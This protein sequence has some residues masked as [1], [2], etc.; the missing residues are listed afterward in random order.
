MNVS[1]PV[2]AFWPPHSWQ[3]VAAPARHVA[4]ASL[5]PWRMRPSLITARPGAAETKTHP[6]GLCRWTGRGLG[7]NDGTGLGRAPGGLLSFPGRGF[8]SPLA[9]ACSDSPRLTTPP[10]SSPWGPQLGPTPPHEPFHLVSN[11][12][13]T[14]AKTQRQQG[15]KWEKSKQTFVANLVIIHQPQLLEAAL[16]N[17]VALPSHPMPLHRPNHQQMTSLPW[18]HVSALRRSR[19]HLS[20]TLTKIILL[21][22]LFCAQTIV[23]ITLCNPLFFSQ[24]FLTIAP[25]TG[26]RDPREPI[27][28][29]PWLA[30]AGTG[31]SHWRRPLFHSSSDVRGRS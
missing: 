24:P 31:A 10:F 26:A 11:N 2:T 28:Q 13:H 6:R 17:T 25:P 8:S 16:E 18:P 23:S 9:C 4:V 5:L 15:P 27:P 21:L 29:G 1:R 19:S 22:L 7:W 3:T 12:H 20:C 14:N 30:G